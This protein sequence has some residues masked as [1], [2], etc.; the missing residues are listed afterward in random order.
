MRAG[1]LAQP[2]PTVSV[3]DDALSSARLM[4]T[5]RAPGLIVCDAQGRPCAVLPGSQVLNFLLPRY[6]QDDPVLARTFAEQAADDLRSR[7]VHHTVREL[8]PPRP[9]ASDLPIVDCDAT[10]I[11]VAALMARLRSPLVA[12]VDQ[13]K[14][15]GAITISA[16]L[17]HFLTP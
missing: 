10:T 14:V 2:Y 8:L 1:Q 11:E 7:L 12:V 5:Q 15:I 16:I 17:M 9:D 6:I 4:A 13:D 3:D